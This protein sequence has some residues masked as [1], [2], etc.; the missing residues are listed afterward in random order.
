LEW[1]Y[2]CFFRSVWQKLSLPNR[3]ELSAPLMSMVKP[4]PVA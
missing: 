1:L 3:Y 4:T 2:W